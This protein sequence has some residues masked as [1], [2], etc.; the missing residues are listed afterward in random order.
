MVRRFFLHRLGSATLQILRHTMHEPHLT[1]FDTRRPLLATFVCMIDM[2]RR[3]TQIRGSSQ[4]PMV[5]Q[6]LSNLEEATYKTRAMSGTVLST[7]VWAAVLSFHQIPDSSIR[8]GPCL[9]L[10]TNNLHGQWDA[11]GC[12]PPKSLKVQENDSWIL[13]DTGGWI[14]FQVEFMRSSRACRVGTRLGSPRA[15]CRF[16]LL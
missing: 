5:L 8:V 13:M 11:C 1:R 4:G 14:N 3:P 7:P 10:H 16:S 9:V 6:T 12:R 15:A 2:Q